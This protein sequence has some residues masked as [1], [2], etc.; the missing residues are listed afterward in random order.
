M[1][2]SVTTRL[3]ALFASVV[4]TVV[5]IEGMALLGH[6]APEAGTEL[7]LAVQVTPAR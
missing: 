3:T 1:N 5:L 7:A 4:V 6:P 2:T